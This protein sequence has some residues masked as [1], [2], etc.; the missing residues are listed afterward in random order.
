M[1]TCTDHTVGKQRPSPQWKPGKILLNQYIITDILGQGGMGVAYLVERLTAGRTRYAV[2][3]LLAA[4]LPDPKSRKSFLRELRIWLDLPDHPNITGCRFFRTVENRMAVFADYVDGGS[5]LKWIRDGKSESLETILDIVIQAARGLQTAHECGIIHQDV[6]PANILLTRDG[7]AKITDF[8]LAQARRIATAVRRSDPQNPDNLVTSNGMTLAYCSPEQAMGTKLHY[9]TDI[10]SLGVTLLHLVLGDVTW[11]MGFLLG[12]HLDKILTQSRQGK[13]IPDR[14]HR[15]LSKCFRQEPEHRWRNMDELAEELKVLY[16]EITGTEYPRPE[17]A[18][19]TEIKITDARYTRRAIAGTTWEDPSD[20]LAFALKSAGRD[21]SEINELIPDKSTA[22]RNPTL[23]DI[24]V[25]N[26]A[27]SI[28]MALYE[29]GNTEIAS[30]LAYL[31]ANKASLLHNLNDHTGALAEFN[32]AIQ[33]YEDLDFGDMDHDLTFNYSLD[34]QNKALLLKITGHHDDAV[35]L[36]QHA[37]EIIT[38]SPD[39]EDPDFQKILALTYTNMATLLAEMGKIKQAISIHDRAI[40]IREKLLAQDDYFIKD[41]SF[42]L[43]NKAVLFRK[44]EDHTGSI[45]LNNRAIELLESERNTMETPARLSTLAQVLNNRA[46]SEKHL[47]HYDT[48][49]SLYNRALSII[50]K[51]IE[52]HDQKALR[53]WLSSM[54][55]NKAIVLAELKNHRESELLFREA[56]SMKQELMDRFGMTDVAPDLAT[57]YLHFAQ[58][59][60]GIIDPQEQVNLYRE[61]IVILKSCYSREKTHGTLMSLAQAFPQWI[62][63]IH[64]AGDETHAAEE[65]EKAKIF[66]EQAGIHHKGVSDALAEYMAKL[67]PFL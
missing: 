60:S 37:I 29:A 55:F 21:L 25:Y 35:A 10:W 38:D 46:V 44:Q 39:R 1:N 6:K 9:R 40:V 8:G 67:K 22:T 56:I 51:L 63:A 4:Q 26:E 57:V 43:M 15:I 14:L 18:V 32:R 11:Q 16:F 24:E 59:L 52:E 49:L 54:V 61:A 36:Y 2:K 5:L 42:S 34:V 47:E 30:E 64:A 13:D 33:I 65:T 28:L 12:E 53:N 23:M 48:A 7:V 66:L 19:D 58:S 45:A 17:P 27:G 62:K 31:L 41:L 20:W 50:E 3:T